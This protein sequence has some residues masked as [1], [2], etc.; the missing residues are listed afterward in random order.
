MHELPSR[1]TS[2]ERYIFGNGN[3]L[4]REIDRNHIAVPQNF[5]P[6]LYAIVFLPWG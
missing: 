3:C 4:E 6:V 1:A 2:F 5:K